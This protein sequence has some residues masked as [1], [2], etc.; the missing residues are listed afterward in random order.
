MCSRGGSVAPCRLQRVQSADQDIGAGC[1]SLSHQ[2][3]QRGF[4]TVV[5][6][7][8]I[9]PLE[10]LGPPVRY[11][12]TP[13]VLRPYPLMGEHNREVFCGMLGLPREEFDRL[14]KEDVII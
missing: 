9:G 7:Q 3:R 14:V 1:T 2:L 12:G 13:S 5:D 8:G 10:H 6:H 4:F 11:A